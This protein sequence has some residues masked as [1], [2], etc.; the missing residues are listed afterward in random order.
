MEHQRRWLWLALF[1]CAIAQCSNDDWTIRSV[2]NQIFSISNKMPFNLFAVLTNG[3]VVCSLLLPTRVKSKYNQFVDE[4]HADNKNYGK[5]DERRV[6]KKWIAK[7]TPRIYNS[8][9]I[10]LILEIDKNLKFNIFALNRI[11][12]CWEFFF[13][14][15]TTKNWNT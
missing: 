14:V 4:R 7:R 8:E 9:Q 1:V 15:T 5:C 13:S 2:C 12:C 10:C 6:K 11:E 3:F